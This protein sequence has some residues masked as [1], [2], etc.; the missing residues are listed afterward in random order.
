MR[1]LGGIL[2]QGYSFNPASDDP[3]PESTDEAVDKHVVE[4]FIEALR[5]NIHAIVIMDRDA[6]GGGELKPWVSRIRKELDCH[7]GLHWV[8]QGREI[9]NY[10]PADAIEKVGWFTLKSRPGKDDCFFDLVRGPEGGDLSKQKTAV[11]RRIGPGLSRDLLE[12]RWTYPKCWTRSVSNSEAG[13]TCRA[14]KATSRLGAGLCR[15]S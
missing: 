15:Q 9:E 6:A 4:E 13:I 7:G 2:I 14:S 11:A 5:I 8:T 10:V 1:Y 3:A 12:A